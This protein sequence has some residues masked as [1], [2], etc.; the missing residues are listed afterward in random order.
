MLYLGHSSEL[1]LTITHMQGSKLSENRD[2]LTQHQV[3]SYGLRR[4]CTDNKITSQFRD[5]YSFFSC[6][7]EHESW[8]AFNALH[9]SYSN[10][11]TE[12]EW[13]VTQ[14]TDSSATGAP[15]LFHSSLFL[16]PW[17]WLISRYPSFA[18][19]PTINLWRCPS[20]YDNFICLEEKH[21]SI[22]HLKV[23]RPGLLSTHTFLFIA[24]GFG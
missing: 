19:N 21:V 1:P 22:S 12:R 20:P 16:P 3:L 14:F 10:W 2:K 24:W 8:Y 5:L 4:S 7:T 9:P 18:P 11:V 15:A 13:W 23:R 17:S 6:K